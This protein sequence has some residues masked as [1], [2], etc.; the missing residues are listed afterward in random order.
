MHRDTRLDSLKKDLRDIETDLAR[1][2]E[3][4]GST[5]L[6]WGRRDWSPAFAEMME[7]IRS[8]D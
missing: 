7:R 3:R 1:C 6:F 2:I 8:A 5:N 4:S